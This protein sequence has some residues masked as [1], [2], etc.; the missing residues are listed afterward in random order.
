MVERII[1]TSLKTSSSRKRKIWGSDFNFGKSK[2]T[3]AGK[4]KSKTGA[5]AIS[6]SD[7][8]AALEKQ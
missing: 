1:W 3:I 2:S 6:N 5:G 8:A 7:S 4:K